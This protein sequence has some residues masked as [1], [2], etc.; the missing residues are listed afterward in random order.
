MMKLTDILF[1]QLSGCAPN[2][3]AAMFALALKNAQS[4]TS[5]GFLTAEMYHLT[6][7]D[8]KQFCAAESN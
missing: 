8:G 1:F 5:V 2:L 7:S 6:T 3:P 4:H